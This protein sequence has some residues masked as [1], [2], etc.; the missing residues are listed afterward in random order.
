MLSKKWNARMLIAAGTT[1]LGLGATS[2]I[3][4]GT[5]TANLPVTATIAANCAISTAAVAFG[6]YDPTVVNATTPLDQ[7]GTVT[8]TCTSGASTTVT[9]GQGA[10]A[11]GGS[12]PAAPVRRMSD[13][14]GTPNY[15]AYS[16]YSDSGHTA[17]WGDTA[18]T[19]VAHTGTGTAT[20]LTV[21]G[22][23]GAGQNVPVG[24]YSDTVVATVTF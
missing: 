12:T 21:Y 24:S 1:V 13:G 22:R 19:G 8:V 2:A 9:L 3:L 4:A 7:P 18:L 16:L 20:N 11:G 6:T 10:N 15:L 5:S 17:V 23:V 14:G